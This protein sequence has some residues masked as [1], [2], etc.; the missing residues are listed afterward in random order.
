MKEIAQIGATIGREFSFSLIRTLV[1]Y[2]ETALQ[3]ALAQLEAAELVFR[4]GEPPEAVYNFKHALVQDAAYESLLK[5]RRQQLHAQIAFALEARFPDIVA[6][7]PEIVAHHFTAAALVGRAIDY[8]LKAGNFA[9]SRSA[10]AEAV[11]H[12][13]QG[14][15]LTLSQP[16]SPTRARTELDFYLALGPATT[17]T[18]GDASPETLR[19]FS[20][21]RDLLGD[22]GTLTE[23]MTVLWGTYL[24]HSMRAEHIA[25]LE[26]AEQCLALA[27]HQ[28]HLGMSALGNR[29]MG[30]TLNFMGSLVTARLKLEQTLALCATNPTTIASYRRFGTDDQVM[31]SSFLAST[32]LLLGYPEQAAVAAAEA[33][34]RARA[35]GLAFTTAS[36]L[37]HVAFLG[38]LG[39]D[40]K[41]AAAHAAEAIAHSV[42]HGLAGPEH[43]AR[44]FQGALLAESGDPQR[45]IELMR[46]AMAT[47]ERNAAR[48]RRTLYLGHL[49]S[50][51]AKLGRPEVGLKSLDE[52]IQMAEITNERFFEAE[53][54]RL[55][56]QMLL[57][58]G[59]KCVGEAALRRAL[60]IARQQQARWW[61]LRAATTLAKHCQTEGNYGE[62][63]LVL[64]PIYNWFVEGFDTLDL[65]T[66]K[67]LV[68]ELGDPSALQT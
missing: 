4:R 66:A 29:F 39:F 2:D 37:S 7:E 38:T 8:W 64:K 14:I 16:P 52:A 42:E 53:L 17:A 41:Q 43:R 31:A 34:S 49:A 11:K 15:E 5:T 48:N 1:G 67:A 27:A 55:R 59:E 21:A 63:C 12:L 47:T 56:G 18:E 25:A 40:R 57:A 28:E 6:S 60:T 30:Q 22:G 9:L 65:K 35:I 36:A 24:A 51:H 44:F 32:L 26:V 62:A 10:N 54:H 33:V 58:L 13:R 45:G 19:V 3:D 20:H 46:N 50:A 23:Q 61:E 68:D